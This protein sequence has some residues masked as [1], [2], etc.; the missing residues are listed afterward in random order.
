MIRR[1]PFTLGRFGGLVALLVASGCIPAMRTG[2]TSGPPPRRAGVPPPLAA[3]GTTKVLLWS[4]EPLP[5]GRNTLWSAGSQLAWD[6]LA[7][8]MGTGGKLTL[9]APAP[10]AVVTG[11]NQSRF[12]RGDLDAASCVIEAGFARE[13]VGRF[14]AGLRR[15]GA[16]LPMPL[17]AL[18][19]TDVAA[20]AYIRKDMPFRQPFHVHAAKLAFAGGSA[21]VFAFGIDP[22]DKGGGGRAMREQ[23]RLHV[24][25]GAARPDGS[26]ERVAVELVPRD[27]KDRIVLAAMPAPAT[28]DE[29]WKLAQGWLALP[30]APLDEDV[31]LVIPKMDFAA[32]RVFDELIPARIGSPP[33]D[34][35]IRDARQRIEFTLSET[36]ARFVSATSMVSSCS[37]PPRVRSIV[38]DRPFL[39]ALVREGAT[40]PY[41]LAWFENDDPFVK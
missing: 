38:F 5:R 18:E 23:T 13:A 2:G 25:E 30:G 36:G 9:G 1:R 19:A 3:A 27:T 35:F 21:R 6:A 20:F 24:P 10:A 29:G 14:Q 22:E 8:Q 4:G 28:L 17:P 39:L 40:R 37:A 34:W 16:S 33:S 32:D 31:K 11:L 7:D 26:A 12:P 15:M 41:F